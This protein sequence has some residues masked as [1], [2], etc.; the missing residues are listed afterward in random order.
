M[1]IGSA[2]ITLRAPWVQSLK[3]KRMIVKS[4]IA[5]LR[6]KF[7]ISAGEVDQQDSHKTIVLG[8]ACIAGDNAMAD[9]I[10]DNVL[11]FIEE[12]CEAE[13]TEV[14]RENL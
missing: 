12:N 9:S 3:E 14:Q 5:K 7:N 4:I 2:V 6:N 11:N 8:M 10:I 1:I 13:I